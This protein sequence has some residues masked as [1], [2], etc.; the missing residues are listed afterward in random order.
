MEKFADENIDEVTIQGTPKIPLYDANALLNITFT[1]P[2]GGAPPRRAAC[3]SA[4]ACSTPELPFIQPVAGSL[5]TVEQENSD[6]VLYQVT[7]KVADLIEKFGRYSVIDGKYD[8][9]L[10]GEAADGKLFTAMVLA[11]VKVQPFGDVAQSDWFYDEVVYVATNGLMNGT[12]G[13]NFTPNGATTRGMIVTMLYR[14]AGSPPS[15]RRMMPGM[16]RR[17]FGPRKRE[18]PMAPTWMGAITREQLAAM[19]YRYAKLHGAGYFRHSG[20]V[21]VPGCCASLRLCH[22][23]HAVGQCQRHYHWPQRQGSG[24][25]GRRYPR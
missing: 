8:Y 13:G 23:G 22:G 12:G 24:A 6:E 18:S 25:P 16:P 7:F 5:K 19:L 4:W 15:P 1:A 14:Q 3:A 11:N 9:F 2:A 21:Q 20:S 17:V 10:G